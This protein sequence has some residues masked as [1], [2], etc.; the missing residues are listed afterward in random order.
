MDKWIK[1]GHWQGGFAASADAEVVAQ[2]SSR[3]TGTF[4]CMLR[5]HRNLSQLFQSLTYLV[6]PNYTVREPNEVPRNAPLPLRF[7][8]VA[9]A[10]LLVYRIGSKSNDEYSSYI[11]RS[12]GTV[13]EVIRLQHFVQKSQLKKMSTEKGMVFLGPW[14]SQ[15][16]MKISFAATRWIRSCRAPHWPYYLYSHFFENFRWY[17]HW[18]CFLTSHGASPCTHLQTIS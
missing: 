9:M 8:A 18:V 1:W 17:Y 2:E 3:M 13:L 16:F 12:C 15:L 14:K 10:T 5:I 4:E 6:P 11:R 7:P